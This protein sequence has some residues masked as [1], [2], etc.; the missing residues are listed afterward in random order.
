MNVSIIVPLYN[1]ERYVEYLNKSIEMQEDVNIESIH[2]ILTESN[3]RTEI[4]L[5]QIDAKYTKIKKSEFCHSLTREK[6]AMN[7]KGDIIIFV[8]Q[9]VIIYSR[10]WLYYLVKDIIE[11]KCEAAFSRQISE[12]KDIEKYIRDINYPDESRIV[13][14]SDIKKLGLMTFFFSDASS[15]IKKDIFVK[16][17]GYGGKKLATNEDMYIAYKLIKNGYKIKYCAD[18]I[19]VHSH[20]FNLKQLYKRYHDI[21]SFFADNSYLNHYK[22]NERGF[23]LIIYILFNSLK[24]KNFKVFLKIVPNFIVRII[25][26]KIGAVKKRN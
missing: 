26:M 7:C 20:E 3:D 22:I 4:I 9:D 6:Y 12:N 14:K 18:S 8:T 13:T 17:N 5:K 16:I 11:G 23:K 2:Y 25:G 10:R 15:A 1:A 21:G 19:V 24:D